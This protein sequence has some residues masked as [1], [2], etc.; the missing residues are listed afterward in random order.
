MAGINDPL[1]FS[2]SGYS[3]LRTREGV[4]YNYYNDLGPR[5]GNC[6]WGVGTLAHFGICTEEELKR[7]VSRT[8]V[9]NA[10]AKHV[11]KLERYLRGKVNK[12]PL[13]QAQFDGLISFS[14]NV[15]DPSPVMELANRGD[16]DGVRSTM[17]KYVYV[18]NHDKNGKKVGPPRL[19]PALY[20]R[21]LEES[22]AFK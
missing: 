9:N 18:F 19:L 6:T 21:R 13:T 3:Q 4:R 20:S 12:H 14:Y 11:Q 8:D 22:S 7:P 2:S 10:L 1:S 16:M 15:S 17:L 5:A